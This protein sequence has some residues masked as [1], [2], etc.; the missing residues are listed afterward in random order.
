M[1]QRYII[2]E[3]VGFLRKPYPLSALMAFDEITRNSIERRAA[4]EE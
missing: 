3:H 4:G 2:H 1:V